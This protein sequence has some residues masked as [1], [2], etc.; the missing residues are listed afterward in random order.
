VGDRDGSASDAEREVEKLVET[1]HKPPPPSAHNSVGTVS[2]PTDPISTVV[3]WSQPVKV[4]PMSLRD[5]SQTSTRGAIPHC[6]LCQSRLGVR[7][8][9]R[10]WASDGVQY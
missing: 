5:V 8:L 10:Q 4:S 6:L 1:P 2:N 7:P 3:A 9:V